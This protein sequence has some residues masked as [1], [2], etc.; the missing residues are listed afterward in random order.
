[1]Y[2][3]SVD[4]RNFRT[5]RHSK[6]VFPYPGKDGGSQLPNVTLL[7]GNNGMGKSSA[8]KAIALALMTPVIADNANEVRT[9]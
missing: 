1:M 3:S 6:A 8:L 4:I 5:F 9:I 7:L 2:L